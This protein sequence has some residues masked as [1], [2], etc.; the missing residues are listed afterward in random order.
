MDAS[1]EYSDDAEL[2]SSGSELKPDSDSD[3]ELASSAMPPPPIPVHK[4][5][6]KTSEVVSIQRKCN[7]Q[8]NH[9]H[10][11][12]L[13]FTGINGIFNCYS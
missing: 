12:A 6:K 9:V 4:K 11:C 13:S 7:I 2:M 1:S 3:S 5:K 10:V 8:L